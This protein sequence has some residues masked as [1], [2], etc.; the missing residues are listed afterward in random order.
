VHEV[1][2]EPLLNRPSD[3]VVERLVEDVHAVAVL[4]DDAQGAQAQ[5][6]EPAA[7]AGRVGG[8]AADD[9]DAADERD[10]RVA[11]GG[12][13]RVLVARRAGGEEEAEPDGDERD[14]DARV[15][16]VQLRRQRRDAERRR[17]GA[18]ERE[19]V[20]ARDRK[21]VDRLPRR[22]QA[23]HHD[24]HPERRDDEREAEPQ[25]RARALAPEQERPDQ[26]ELLLDAER[27]EVREGAAAVAERLRPVR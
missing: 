19:C 16:G 6:R 21:R 1:P 10:Q 9:G 17:D 24:A 5:R 25:H 27:P 8:G 14:P 11:D 4:A 2:A 23:Q 20:H 13:E 22:V 3:E 18:A 12:A 7:R 15:D 26:V